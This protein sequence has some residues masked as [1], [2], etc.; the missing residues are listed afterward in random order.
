MVKENVPRMDHS[1]VRFF[2][3]ELL[4]STEPPY[5]ATFA[6][7]IHSII[8]MPDATLAIKNDPESIA[9]VSAFAAHCDAMNAPDLHDSASNGRPTT[10]SQSAV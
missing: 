7:R 9:Q 1:L 4:Q 2:V 3:V 10:I 6:H 8:S 5:S